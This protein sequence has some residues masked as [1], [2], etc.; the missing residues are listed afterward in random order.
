M[1]LFY[2]IVS[3]GSNKNISCGCITYRVTSA[4]VFFQEAIGEVV[5]ACFDACFDA[6]NGGINCNRLLTC[7]QNPLE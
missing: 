6:D 2:Q 1:I 4:I 5:T 3:S 7:D